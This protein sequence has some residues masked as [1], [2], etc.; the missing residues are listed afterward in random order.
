VLE[1]HGSLGVEG[2]RETV[3]RHG[4][5]LVLADGARKRLPLRDD[6]AS[7]LPVTTRLRVFVHVCA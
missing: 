2:V 1:R 3:A 6:V 7:W 5:G 4:F